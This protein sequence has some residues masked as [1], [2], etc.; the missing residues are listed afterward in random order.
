MAPETAEVER[1]AVYTFRGQWAEQW[2][3]GRALLAGDAAHLMPPFAGQGLCSGLRDSMALAWRIDAI[4]RGVADQSLL[5][6]FICVTDPEA[7]RQRDIN[8]LA[9]AAEL[10]AAPRRRS[11]AWGLDFGAPAPLA[12]ASSASTGRILSFARLWGVEAHD[13]G[14]AFDWLVVD[15]RPREEREWSP[16]TWQL[17]VRA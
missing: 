4:L 2:R 5:D 9:G 8:M 14:F 6:S 10:S 13:L 1:H 11:R 17:C 15:V 3:V 7:A 16:K 12:E